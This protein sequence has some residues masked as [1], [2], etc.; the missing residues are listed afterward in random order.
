MTVRAANV[1]FL[2]FGRHHGPWFANHKQG[3]VLKLGCAVT[4][5]ELQRDDVALPTVNAGVRAEIFP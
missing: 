4:V 1:A 2:D 5:I 3:D